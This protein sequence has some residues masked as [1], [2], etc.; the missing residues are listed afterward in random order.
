MADLY[1]PK[2]ADEL[3][4]RMLRD[5]RLAALDAG[6]AEP[7]TQPG[8][9]LHIT[10]TMDGNTAL[11]GF[12]NINSLEQDAS[13]FT[14]TGA[15]LDQMRKDEGLPEVEP[16]GAKGRLKI[17]VLGPTTIPNG[18]RFRYPNG[19]LGRVV[20]GAINP[21][22][23]SEL[24]V[25]AIS[26]GSATNLRS[27]TA[28]T[29]IG[30]PINLVA[31]AKVSKAIPLS[32]GTDAETDERKRARILNVRRN[33]PAGGNWAQIRQVMLDSLGSVQDGYVYPCLGGPSSQKAVPVK[34]FDRENND[35]SRTLSD[36]A[37]AIVRAA[38]QAKVPSDETI[39]QSS[40]DQICDIALQIEIPD[41]YLAGGNGQGWVDAS[42]WPPLVGADNGRVMVSS[43]DAD[44]D[45]LTVTANTPTAPTDGLTHIA[46]WSSVDRKFYRALVVGHSGSI[47][48]WV[49]NLDRPLV[50]SVGNG[51]I[52]GGDYISPDAQNLDAYGALWVDIFEALGPG[53]NTSSA[54][55]LPRAKRHP[56]VTDE[57]A[58][59]ITRAT[60]GKLT[61]NYPEITD[62]EFSYA[63]TTTPTVPANVSIAP[64]VLIPRR[65]A[66]YPL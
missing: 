57:D 12:A 1:Q 35:Y 13:V 37:L 15:A 28:V 36:A 30:P 66:C 55:R 45:T 8:S 61:A 10:A 56:Y 25:E 26:T 22:T 33:K 27:D 43:T 49:L 53:E 4:Q 5:A 54:D 41:S 40:V 29:F 11:I 46:W 42:P 19:L 59:S 17:E 14:A 31:Q 38:V 48:A 39:L 60:L 2:N 50:D 6:L 34:G 47:G 58:S 44:F 63:P 32:G 62:I 21:A 52:L 16:T 7:P 9:D 3:I 65:F 23:N 18:L 20:G 24:D 64:N 51:P